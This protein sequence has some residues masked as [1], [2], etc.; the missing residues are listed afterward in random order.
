[1]GA[2]DDEEMAAL[3]HNAAAIAARTELS[4]LVAS[5]RMFYIGCCGGSM[6]TGRYFTPTRKYSMLDLFQ[7]VSEGVDDEDN[8]KALSPHVNLTGRLGCFIHVSHIE[9]QVCGFICAKRNCHIFTY[10][11]GH[12]SPFCLSIFPLEP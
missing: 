1:M 12:S 2:A 11:L 4:R 6:M 10:N 3:W 8:S 7:G 9:M 5:G